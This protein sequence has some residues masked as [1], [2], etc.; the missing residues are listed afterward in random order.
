MR[1]RLVCSFWVCFV[2]FLCVL[3]LPSILLASQFAFEAID[4]EG[5]GGTGVLGINDE[6][7]LVGASF[8]I[9]GNP[10]GFLLDKQGTVTTISYDGAAWTIAAG[11]NN[12][13]QVIGLYGNSQYPSNSNG[14]FLYE[15]GNFIDIP[16]EPISEGDE[17]DAVG[18][19]SQGFIVGLLHIEAEGEDDSEDVGYVRNPEGGYWFPDG[20]QEPFTGGF[21]FSDINS[22][23]EIAGFGM[24]GDHENSFLRSPSGSYMEIVH[25]PVEGFDKIDTQVTGLNERG[26]IIGNWTEAGVEALEGGNGFY[27]DPTGSITDFKL[28]GADRIYASKINSSGMIV[29]FY[30]DGAGMMHGFVARKA[31]FIW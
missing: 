10:Q 4:I 16:P 24:V 15:G 12:K 6:G 31:A 14:A 5:S 1:D 18:I 29:G 20:P 7:E 30:V 26:E 22:R 21:E 13:G 17:V 27:R 9:S 2:G 3:A 28:D 23:G 25:S 19:N 8:D 11:I